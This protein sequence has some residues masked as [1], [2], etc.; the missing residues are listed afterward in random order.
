MIKGSGGATARACECSMRQASGTVGWLERFTKDAT[1]Q[2][3]EIVSERPIR[4]AIVGIGNCASSLIQGLSFYRNVDDQSTVAGLMNP[5]LG[6]YRIRDIIPCAAYDVSAEKVGTDLAEAIFA[7]PNN[8]AVFSAV[9]A[10]GVRVERGPTLDGL[11]PTLRGLI[12]ESAAPVCDVARSLREA[13][14]DVLVSYLPVGSEEAACFYAEQALLAGCGFI[15]CMPTFIASREEWQKRFAQQGLPLIGDDIKSQLG[16]TIVHRVL[17]KLFDDRGVNLE[18]TYQL[19]FGGNADFRNMLD[20]ERLVSKRISKTQS[21]QSQLQ[22]ELAATAIHIGPSDHIEWLSDRKWAHIRMEGRSFGNQPV[23]IDLKLEVWD[24]P[25]SA[26]VVIDAIRCAALAKKRGL[27]G[28]LIAASSYFMKS[29][30]Q[31]FSDAQALA[32]LQA[33]IRGDASSIY[34]AAE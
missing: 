7:A 25:N 2:K 26:G 17:T 12:Q 22:H 4:I 23:T 9:P 33:F 3:D 18:R 6:G 16:A 5:V 1:D 13:R 14:T 34:E 20:R 24:S 8:T 28:P 10:T 11:G 27:G 32:H 21:V 19:N 30:P 31:Q 29:P 15:N